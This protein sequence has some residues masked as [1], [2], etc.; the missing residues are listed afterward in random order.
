MDYISNA[1]AKTL[2]NGFIN[3]AMNHFISK[4][5][6]SSLRVINWITFINFSI[7]S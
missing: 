5:N 4:W 7:G 1:Y 3:W 6:C 2:I